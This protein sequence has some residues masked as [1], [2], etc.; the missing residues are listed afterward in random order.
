MPV[1]QILKRLQQSN[2]LYVV[3]RLG[4]QGLECEGKAEAAFLLVVL[5]AFTHTK[6]HYACTTSDSILICKKVRNNYSFQYG[7]SLLFALFT[8]L[9][10]FYDL[11]QVGMEHDLGARCVDPHCC[12]L[13]FYELLQ[14]GKEHDLSAG[15][16]IGGKK[17]KE[18]QAVVNNM[19]IL[20]STPGE[21][22]AVMLVKFQ[23]KK[24]NE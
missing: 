11:L 20:V 5:V 16:L 21:G 19:N 10:L 12:I 17:V 18:E 13:F 8:Q 4:D 2:L 23:K 22:R 14:V 9:H 24:E 7:I 15:L 1:N 6:S 3:D